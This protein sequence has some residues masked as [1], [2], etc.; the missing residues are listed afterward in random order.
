[1]ARLKNAKPRMQI[2]GSRFLILSSSTF[3]IVLRMRVADGDPVRVGVGG[4]ASYAS[5]LSRENRHATRFGMIPF[6]AQIHGR[7][8]T[9]HRR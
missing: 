4:L 9:V 6:E 5:I 8:E 1:M 7:C 2:D 3:Q